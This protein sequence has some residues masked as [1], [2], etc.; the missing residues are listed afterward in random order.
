[1]C[2]GPVNGPVFLCS[3]VLQTDFQDRFTLWGS[4]LHLQS[5]RPTVSGPENNPCVSENDFCSSETFSHS[6]SEAQLTT[7]LKYCRKV[8]VPATQS[9]YF[10]L[11]SERNYIE[12]FKLHLEQ[13]EISS[14][15]RT[16]SFMR[17]IVLVE[18]LASVYGTS[19]S[20]G[21]RQGQPAGVG[22]R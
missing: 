18:E 7:K 6:V 1:M 17:V 21:M 12:H 22:A 4:L 5:Q 13:S 10:F 11:F 14:T 15:C 16:I 8:R 9:I 19:E 20:A 2:A 3:P